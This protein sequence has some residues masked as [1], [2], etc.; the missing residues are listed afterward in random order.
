MPVIT[1]S[2]PK[3]G[4]GKT[5]SAIILAS[6]LAQS[7]SVELIDADPAARAF[8]WAQR[9]KI[10]NKMKLTKS[11]GERY[12]QDEIETARSRSS[13]IIVDLE[14]AATQLNSMTI[15]ESD[16]IIVPTGDE[17]QDADAAVEALAQI[18]MQSRMLRRNIP[19][20]VLFTRTKAAVKARNEKEIN[21]SLRQNVNTFKVELNA[22]TAFSSLHSFGGSLY[23]LDEHGVGGCNK[24]IENA[25]LFAGE[26]IEIIQGAV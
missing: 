21:L 20:M 5:T 18:K 16:L 17:Q 25:E 4:A 3:G 1:Y 14:G 15:A 11:K 6:T 8:A 10:P 13:F 19:A 22:R 12:I 26:V 23:S 2:S 24:A 7:V 9:G